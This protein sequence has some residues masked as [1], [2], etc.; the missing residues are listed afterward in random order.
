V[1]TEFDCILSD[2][3]AGLQGLIDGAETFLA[4]AGVPDRAAAQT[5]IALDE[6]VSN[7]F[8]HGVR[9]GEPTVRVHLKVGE[10][11]IS[12]A[13]DDDGIAFDPLNA[14]APDTT[15]PAEE[16]PIGGLGLHI[17]RKTM[18]H[19]RYDRDHGRNRLR[20]HKTFGVETRD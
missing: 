1:A 10:G 12:G 18:D 5:L 14:P 11:R 6:V 3:R 13:I 17:V 9:E 16:R 2:G 19:I 15:L 8:M 20:F 7:I 4:K